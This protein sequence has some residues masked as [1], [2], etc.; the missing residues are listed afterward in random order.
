M[1]NKFC[2]VQTKMANKTINIGTEW[3]LKADSC[4]ISI[5]NVANHYKS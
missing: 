1:K 2:L 4:C 5:S 3:I